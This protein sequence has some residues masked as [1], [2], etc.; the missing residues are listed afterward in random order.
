MNGAVRKC[1]WGKA[2]RTPSAARQ[3]VNHIPPHLSYS[4]SQLRGVGSVV[5]LEVRSAFISALRNAINYPKAKQNVAMSTRPW[6][7]EGWCVS[8]VLHPWASRTWITEYDSKHANGHTYTLT[9]H[10]SG[11]Q[12][13]YL[14]DL[15]APLKELQHAGCKVSWRRREGGLREGARAEGACVTYDQINFLTLEM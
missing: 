11:P 10:V 12:A 7:L 2:K 15:V 14:M 6:N 3:A 4:T 5:R 9:E 1:R 13:G 8:N